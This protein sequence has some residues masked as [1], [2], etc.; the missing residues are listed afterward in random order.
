MTV[1]IGI[2]YLREMAYRVSPCATVWES[3]VLRSFRSDL[4]SG[5]AVTK[6]ILTFSPAFSPPPADGL[7]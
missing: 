3:K 6:G 7:Y 1:W 5:T 2:S 4:G